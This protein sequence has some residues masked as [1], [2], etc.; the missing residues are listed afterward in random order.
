V[1]IL[2]YRP[3]IDGLR[4]LAVLSVVINHVSPHSL[5]GGFLGVDIFFVIS[6]YLISLIVFREQASGKFSFA[7]FYA[8][9]IRR[10]F[11]ALAAMLLVTLVFGAFA[12]FAD[13]YK[14]L[15]NHAVYAIGFLLNFQLMSEAGY[16]D[17]ASQTKPLLHLWSLSVE[18]QFYLVWPALIIAIGRFRLRIDWIIWLLIFSSFLFAIYLASRNHGAL[19]FHPFARCWEL[20]VGA[21]LAFYHHRFGINALPFL[22]D[23]VWARNL[24]SVV[25]M[26]AIVMAFFLSGEKP[27]P[28][29]FTLISLIGVAAL[30]ASGG[31]SFGGRIL[32]IQPMV[33]LGLISYPLYLWHWPVLAYIRI[34]KSDAVP[35]EMLLWSGACGAL[36]LAT[37]TYRY[38]ELPMR[39]LLRP[40][41]AVIGLG[42]I[43]AVLSFA[44]L[45]V[46]A[47]DGFP[48]RPALGYVTVAEAQ[49][50]RE[51]DADESCRRLFP[52]GSAPAYCRQHNPGP[53]MI[54]IIGDSH[55]HVLFPGFSEQAERAGYGVLLLANS[56]CPPLEGTV[57]GKT[58]SERNGCVRSVE[59]ILSELQGDERIKHIIVA[60]RGPIYLTGKGY[61]TAEAD[62]D[63][64]PIA[65]MNPTSQKFRVGIDPFRD[66]L[67]AT[68]R[69]LSD[70]GRT[71]TYFLQPPELG[72]PSRDCLGRPLE[73]GSKATCALPV[74]QYKKR[75]GE[76]RAI[77][78]EAKAK[79]PSM[80]V[81]D[82]QPLFCDAEFCQGLIEDKLM[83]ADDDHLSVEGS[84][85]V[86]T[87][88]F[89]LLPFAAMDHSRLLGH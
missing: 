5:P 73:F 59:K 30:I 21:L 48:H 36:L 17:V 37:L 77:V 27:D 80:S 65:Y 31:N 24:L 58:E 47:S 41:T 42:S 12:L 62:Y 20:L 88:F 15:G 86:A 32:G 54:G 75:M 55:A 44:S 83:Y 67:F 69:R 84:R 23:R 70:S 52:Q 13:E 89:P 82:P 4:G 78:A 6:G 76:Y 18:E 22:L 11:P 74:V 72:V 1:T 46:L 43:M 57:T 49:M 63:H 68:L 45:G 60:T 85:R 29:A 66:G 25:G 19:H 14:R 8:R 16:F 39:S 10:I 87:H 38:I 7:D 61:G 2:K 28:G 50:K 35:G 53:R 3:D 51:P 33:W 40:R 34:I 79:F 71:V 26:C 56:G 81:W 64:P 9:R